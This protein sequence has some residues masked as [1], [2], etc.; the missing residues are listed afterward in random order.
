MMKNVH[1]KK[2]LILVLG[3]VMVLSS[4]PATVGFAANQ[5][6]TVDLAASTGALKYGAVG[7]LYGLG[8]EGIPSANMLAPLKMQVFNQKP[9]DG[10]QH[11][12]GDVLKVAPQFFNNGGKEIQI[13]IQD[14]YQQWPYDNKGINDYLA[15]VDAAVAKVKASAYYGKIVYVPFNEPDWIWYNVSDKKQTMFND[16]KTVYNRIRSQDTVSKIAGP[17]LSYY[18]NTFYG[19]FLTFCKSNSCLPD[20]ITWH[21]LNGSFHADW[22]TH[23]TQYRALETS[24]S[25]SARP[26][27]INEYL[28]TSSDLGNP[29]S[30]V[31]YMAKF[32]KDKVDGCTAYW[33]SAGAMN[34]CVTQNN[35][36]TGGWWL[37]K[38][39]S[40]MTGNT[41]S[42]T[43][44]NWNA[45]GLQG[46]AA[47]DSTRKQA[48]VI[49]GGSASS[50]DVIVKG[51]G[52]HTYFGSTVHVTIWSIA[53]S[54]RTSAGDMN[55]SSG[56]AFKQEGDYTVSNGQIT[57]PVTGM[58]ATSAYLMIVTPDKDLS[59]ASTSGRY[60]AEYANLS[61]S[62]AVTYGS[63]TGYSGTSFV[64]GYGASS[65]A[66]TNFV[67]TAA[68]DG[69][70][71]VTL[72][73]S[74]GPFTGAPTARNLRLVINGGL[75]R[76]V[77]CTQ[78]ADWNTWASVTTKV[79]LQA[80]I[81]R[82]SYQAYTSDES[83]CANIDYIDVASTTGT[84]TAYEA[85]ASANTLAGTAVRTSN[86]A[87][88]GGQFVGYLGGGSANT[89]T[90][91]N[92]NAS[93]AGT[94]RLIIQYAN[95][96]L[97]SGASNYNSNVVDRYADISVN[98]GTS[99][100]LYFRN[101]FGW[102]TFRT[103]MCDVTLNAGNNTIKFSNSSS[104]F[105]PDID[106]ISIAAP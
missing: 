79:F 46:L 68:N 83:D 82:L 55:P 70:Y 45:K 78:T 84:I 97:G 105:C 1:V 85:E 103:T 98:G 87:A 104:G 73:Y 74:A 32:E 36:A 66:S 92:V 34:D 77:A 15:K 94:Y 24:R 18:D 39:Y 48:R 51:F 69:Y 102:S 21:E 60:E 19:D 54:G 81:N 28:E 106:K 61:G 100:R 27:S 14:M 9:P 43:P 40:D 47:V 4:V 91:N 2:L 13:N 22:N 49:F 42:V 25:I 10:L 38:W 93:A 96:E 11:P 56:P 86:S 58:N 76:T 20:I 7:A 89:L 44:P 50:T 62:A 72:R 3:I 63:N 52:S 23:L 8:D 29:G 53:S 35:K 41:V 65:N 31:R 90:I 59:A 57:V 12:N 33:T 80:G 101:T 67:V 5:Q 88:S 95:G 6:F 37:Y 17:N 16:W 26:I 64:E 71:N 99:Q 75:T 30:I